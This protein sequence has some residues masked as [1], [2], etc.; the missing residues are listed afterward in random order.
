[1]T[2]LQTRLARLQ[3]RGRKAL[4]PFITAG[5]PSLQATVR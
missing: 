4:I 3:A 1:M 5:D 2:R